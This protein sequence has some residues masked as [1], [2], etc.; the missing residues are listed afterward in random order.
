MLLHPVPAGREYF[1][2]LIHHDEEPGLAAGADGP[3]R[4]PGAAAAGGDLEYVAPVGAARDE[5]RRAARVAAQG[6]LDAAAACGA[7]RVGRVQPAGASRV[8]PAGASR[9]QPGQLPGQ[10]AKRC[11][12]RCEQG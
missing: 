10:L 2:K 5:P 4:I 6:R 11:G 1:L 3:G 8:Q 7:V 12:P 9:V